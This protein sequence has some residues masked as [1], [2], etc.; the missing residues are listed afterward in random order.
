M[1]LIGLRVPTATAPGMA[2]RPR[3]WVHPQERSARRVRK[4]ICRGGFWCISTCSQSTSRRRLLKYWSGPRC[5]RFW[6]W[7]RREHSADI[8]SDLGQASNAGQR[9]NRRNLAGAR[10]KGHLAAS[11]ARYSP[12]EGMRLTRSLPSASSAFYARP[13]P[14]SQ[15]SPRC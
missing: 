15:Q 13:A 10:Q 9:Q 14:V 2:N 8:R 7:P 3:S 4:I 12:V 6:R 5:C 1:Q 11:L